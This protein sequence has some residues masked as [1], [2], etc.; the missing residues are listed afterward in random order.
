MKSFLPHT[1]YFE[2][3]FNKNQLLTKL[4]QILLEFLDFE[5]NHKVMNVSQ[6]VIKFG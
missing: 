2:H 3:N 4:G 6:W 5:K 1:L